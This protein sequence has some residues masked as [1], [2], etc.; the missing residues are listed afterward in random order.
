[1]ISTNISDLEDLSILDIIICL[2]FSV[3]FYVLLAAVIVTADKI[4]IV[5]L[6]I[7]YLLGSIIQI[8]I[9]PIPYLHHSKME[10][11][12]NMKRLFN[13]I[14]HINLTSRTKS[15]I[16]YPI[17]Y[18][19]DITGEINIPENIEYVKIGRIQYYFEEDFLTSTKQY[20]SIMGNYSI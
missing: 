16:E 14:V 8:Y 7:V 3:S 17:K 11:D 1:M 18:I 19:S 13:S 4:A 9:V 12:E 10:F 2:I 6:I 20:K 15:N 5:Y